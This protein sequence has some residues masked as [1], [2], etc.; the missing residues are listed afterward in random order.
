MPDVCEFD[1]WLDDGMERVSASDDAVLEAD[2]MGVCALGVTRRGLPA[3]RAGGGVEDD[4]AWVVGCSALT[5]GDMAASA[6]LRLVMRVRFAGGRESSANPFSEPSG[7]L[8]ISTTSRFRL[9]V[10]GPGGAFA[11]SWEYHGLSLITLCHDNVW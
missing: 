11:A 1:R 9:R 5:D 4:A 3:R 7:E 2:G 6:A 8:E 10:A